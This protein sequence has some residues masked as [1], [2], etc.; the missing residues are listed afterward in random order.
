MYMRI[1]SLMALLIL[2]TGC[3]SS[4]ALCERHLRAINAP[5][6]ASAPQPSGAP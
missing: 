1:S 6:Q 4:A 3:A 5:E 2:V